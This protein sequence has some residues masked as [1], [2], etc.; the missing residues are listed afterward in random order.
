MKI[1][2]QTL[3]DVLPHIS[4]DDGIVVSERAD[5]TM[6]D[7]VFVTDN[8]SA[9]PIAQQCRGLKFGGDERLI[10][11]P[12][13]KFFNIGER[14][15]PNQV[16]WTRP[17]V[18][19]DK[20]DGSMIHPAIIKDEMVFMTRM[21]ITDQARAALAVAS[22]G[23]KRLS[24]DAMAAGQTPIFEFTGPDN[25]VVVEYAETAITLLAVRD[26]ISGAYLS[27]ADLVALAGRYG[28]PVAAT[29]GQVTDANAFVLQGR[30]LRDVE[31][32]VVAFEDGHRLKLKADAYALRH[33]ALAGVSLEKNVLAWIVEGAVDDVLPLL[34]DDVADRVRTYQSQLMAKV[35]GHVADLTDFAD[36][37]DM[38]DRRTYA[39]A[40]KDKIDRRL[41]PAA[42]ALADGRDAR[43]AVL[44][45][46]KWASGSENRVHEVRD[47][48]D[49]DWKG[50]DLVMRDI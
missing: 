6:V 16:D 49:L 8:T 28:V 15:Q 48:F 43:A 36:G 1:E 17:H 10:A 31:G 25:R 24:A 50:S 14:E 2:I 33:K 4:Y 12:F 11:R 41:Q 18:I 42:F 19:M 3:D 13:H 30:A 45:L 9:N 47:L 22:D 5:Y 26:I 40:V 39:M 21:G 37:F 20:L 34:H 23:V 46:L 29:F 44:K 7:Y 27:H 35:N 38:S 32:Y